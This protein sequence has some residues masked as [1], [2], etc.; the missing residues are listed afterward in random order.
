[1]N[2][3][4][5]TLFHRST[6]TVYPDTPCDCANVH[7]LDS[8]DQ[9]AG[10]IGASWGEWPDP[11]DCIQWAITTPDEVD[12][13]LATWGIHR[14]PTPPDLAPDDTGDLTT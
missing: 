3:D 4:K 8:K 11:P 1:M 14:D 5:L 2:N 12:G 13:W 10:F 6:D 7:V 9:S